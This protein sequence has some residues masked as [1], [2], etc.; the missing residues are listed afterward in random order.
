MKNYLRPSLDFEGRFYFKEMCELT[1][2]CNACLE[3]KLLSEFYDA[4]PSRCKECCRVENKKHRENN[5]IL[6]K[7]IPDDNLKICCTCKI[8]KS[9][10]EFSKKSDTKD[11]FMKRCKSCVAEHHQKVKPEITKTM[12]I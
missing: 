4:T 5:K 1:K 12:K 6:E 9:I 7:V 10:I 3:E 11:G 8:E 2:K